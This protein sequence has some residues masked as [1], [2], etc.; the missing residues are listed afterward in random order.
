M[1]R[2]ILLGI[3]IVAVLLLGGAFIS[4]RISDPPLHTVDTPAFVASMG[5]HLWAI[6]LKPT[7]FTPET[8]SVSLTY[9]NALYGVYLPTD[10]VYLP[11]LPLPKQ[12]ILTGLDA[13][14][15]P[16]MKKTFT[17]RSPKK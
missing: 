15:N 5:K 6:T 1:I 16:I 9:N 14:G 7:Y 13:D 3:A 17:L 11:V 12:V 2:R 8:K 4:K 10:K